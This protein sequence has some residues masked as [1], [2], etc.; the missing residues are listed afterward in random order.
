MP[1]DPDRLPPPNALGEFIHPDVP[2][3]REGD[4]IVALCLQMGFY[5]VFVRFGDDAPA[6]LR[7]AYFRH[8]DNGVI[9]QWSPTP[10]TLMPAWQLVAKYDSDLGPYAMFVRPFFSPR[11][12]LH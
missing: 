5:S 7:D 2:G 12:N 6:P 4:N 1:F 8:S 10:P 11:S 3:R 9:A